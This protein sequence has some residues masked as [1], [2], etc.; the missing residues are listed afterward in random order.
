MEDILVTDAQLVTDQGQIT[1]FG[2][3][4]EP[5]SCSRLFQA[6]AACGV[7]VDMI[8]QN[9]AGGR[10]EVSFSV[11]QADLERALAW[12]RDAVED[13]DP[14]AEVLADNALATVFV[15]GVG[16]RTH[17]G[18]ARRMFGALARRGIN[19]GMINTSEVCISVVVDRDRGEEALECLKE[20]FQM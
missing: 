5:G 10:P 13:L 1:I 2:L 19:I 11:P 16:M 15:L 8:V 12:T 3:P 4:D 17:T 20:A 9:L 18:V 7:V 14:R 6:V